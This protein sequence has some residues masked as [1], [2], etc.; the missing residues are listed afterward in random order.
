MRRL[1]SVNDLWLIE[2]CKING[3]NL[4]LMMMIGEAVLMK[5][6]NFSWSGN[7]GS[8]YLVSGLKPEL[9]KNTEAFV[10]EGLMINRIMQN[11]Q[12]RFDVADDDD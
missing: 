12:C 9:S 11:Q 10:G 4:M 3:V 2:S 8:K 7:E 1:W 6:K 5:V